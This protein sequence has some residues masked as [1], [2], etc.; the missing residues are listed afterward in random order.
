M[1][2]HRLVA[3]AIAVAA[4]SLAP[5]VAAASSPRL[6]W[7]DLHDGG[8]NQLD[9]GYVALADADGNAIIGGVRTAPDGFTDFL[10][11]KLDRITGAAIWTYVYEDPIGNNMALAD[12]VLDHRGD[13]LIAGYLSS[14]DT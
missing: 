7:S 2:R 9:D 12:L 3:A 10:V 11:R 13:L 4:F 6:G 5:V 14:C 1:N 8:A